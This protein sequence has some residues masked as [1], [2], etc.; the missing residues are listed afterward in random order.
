M[1]TNVWDETF[2]PDSEAANLLASNQ[3][4]VQ[5]NIRERMEDT[6]YNPGTM[7]GTAADPVVR[8]EILGNISQAYYNIHHSEFTVGP[9]TSILVGRQDLYCNLGSDGTLSLWAPVRFVTNNGNTGSLIITNIDVNV[10]TQANVSNFSWK[11][12]YNTFGIAPAI[13]DV[14][15][16]SGT[17]TPVG[18]L[19]SG[20]IAHTVTAGR[21]Y[22]AV[23]TLNSTAGIS[24]R[25]Y[26]MSITYSKSDSRVS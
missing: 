4:V 19:T 13:T 5:K 26:G 23:V 25:F 15:S 14:F 16:G 24:H 2:P 20:I 22:F 8:P 11:L 21:M 6:L 18:M 7:N 10:D 3:R 12:S 9:E 17:V 1:P